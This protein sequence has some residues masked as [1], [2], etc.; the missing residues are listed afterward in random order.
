MFADIFPTGA[1]VIASST[2]YATS[3]GTQFLPII[4]LV[5]GLTV[6]IVAIRFVTRKTKGAIKAIGKKH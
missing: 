5:V 3:W 6:A 4:Y 2:E 1:E